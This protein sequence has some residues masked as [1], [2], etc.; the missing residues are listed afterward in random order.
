MERQRRNALITA[1]VLALMAL[2]IYAVI[3][4]KYMVR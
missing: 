4:V 2:G 3:V 1:V